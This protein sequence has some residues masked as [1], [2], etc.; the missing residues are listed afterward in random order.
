MKNLK[1][2]IAACESVSIA[3]NEHKSMDKTIEYLLPEKV[4]QQIHP[5]TYRTMLK[6]DSL[7]EMYLFP[8]NGKPHKLIHH[9]LDTC[10]KKALDIIESLEINT[11]DTPTDDYVEDGYFEQT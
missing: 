7:I 5:I 3:I 9:D 4:R 11:P 2:I 10:I 8:E 6:K 1:K